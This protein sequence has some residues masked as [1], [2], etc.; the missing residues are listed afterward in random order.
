MKRNTIAAG[1]IATALPMAAA[2][3][4]HAAKSVVGRPAVEQSGSGSWVAAS[5]GV[6][7][8]GATTGRPVA[9]ATRGFVQTRDGSLPTTL[10]TC[11]DGSGT[12][13][14]WSDKAT[15]TLTLTGDI[16]AESSPVGDITVLADYDVASYG[17]SKVKPG[18]TGHGQVFIRFAADGSATW[19]ITGDLH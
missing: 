2:A 4:A 14:T 17:G 7:F 18:A 6:G 9:G 16:C 12:L 8:T 5:S 1:V 13:S 10:H 15:L 3:P 19:S 11:E